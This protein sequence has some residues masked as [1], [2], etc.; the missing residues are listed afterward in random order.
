MGFTIRQE[1]FTEEDLKDFLFKFKGR[2]VAL[3][4]KEDDKT[5]YSCIYTN[6]IT[7]SYV[8][9]L[10]DESGLRYVSLIAERVFALEIRLKEE[11]LNLSE[12]LK[13]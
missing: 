5:Y 11:D 8:N 7:S 2:R 10:L 13:D 6:N 4:Y 9:F 1:G 3:L 12:L